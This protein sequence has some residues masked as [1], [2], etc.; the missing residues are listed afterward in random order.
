MSEVIEDTS[1][2]ATQCLAFC[3]TLASQG[4]A[5]KFSL[6]LG[7]SFSFILD[8]KMVDSSSPKARKRQSPSTIKR[9]YKRRQEFL[10]TKESSLNKSEKEKSEAAVETPT[11]KLSQKPKSLITCDVCGHQTKTKNGM[12]LHKKNKHEI[13][14]QLDGFVEMDETKTDDRDKHSEVTTAKVNKNNLCEKHEKLS[15]ELNEIWSGLTPNQAVLDSCRDC[16]LSRFS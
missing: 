3:Q 8:T 7:K 13:G 4:Q 11:V 10:L 5:F 9:N 16:A 2:L 1:P 6:T 15:Y 14:D 12:E